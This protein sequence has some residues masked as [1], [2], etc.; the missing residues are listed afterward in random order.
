MLV[1]VHQ[2][3]RGGAYTCHAVVLEKCLP[4]SYQLKNSYESEKDIKIPKNRKTF[5]QNEIKSKAAE[6]NLEQSK[7]QDLFNQNWKEK[8]KFGVLRKDWILFDEAFSF[9]FRLC[10]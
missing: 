7:V 10:K 6:F 4:D 5:Y 2:F 3:G 1:T 9:E 8:I